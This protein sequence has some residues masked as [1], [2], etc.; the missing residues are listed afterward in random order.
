[1]LLWIGFLTIAAVAGSWLL[2]IPVLNYVSGFDLSPYK[3]DLVIIMLGGGA[4]ALMALFYYILTVMRKQY[5]VLGGY[6]FG[7]LVAIIGSACFG[8]ALCY[9]RGSCCVCSSYVS[10]FYCIYVYDTI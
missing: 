4:N 5:L 2:G 7:F 1:M 10:D 3:M 8:E 6:T 9:K